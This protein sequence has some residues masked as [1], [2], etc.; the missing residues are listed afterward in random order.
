V[1]RP[2]L[3]I[4]SG[5]TLLAAGLLLGTLRGTLWGVVGMTLGAI[6]AFGIARILGR[7]E[8]E[9]RLSGAVS[10]VD[11]YL[12]RRGPAWLALFTAL[13]TTP[14]TG[15]HS[16]AGLSSMRP[17]SFVVGAAGGLLP[18]CAMFAYFGDS[19]VELD[20]RGLWT[21]SII[22]GAAFLVGFAL[23]RHLLPPGRVPGEVDGEV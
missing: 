19:L 8:I 16:A 6:L 3:L 2:F 13:P 18:R 15:L 21:A 23:R 11:R 7:Q 22:L 1:F 5:V 4:P 9:R 10:R 17:A 20:A 14:L 12:G